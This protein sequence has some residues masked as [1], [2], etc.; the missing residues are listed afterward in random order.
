MA[1]ALNPGVIAPLQPTDQEA[2]NPANN[3]A[4]AMDFDPLSGRTVP[5]QNP[6]IQVIK[7][8]QRPSF[9]HNE[10][11]P[12][13]AAKRPASARP[14]PPPRFPQTYHVTVFRPHGG[15]RVS[16]WPTSELARSLAT[17]SQMSDLQFRKEITLQAQPGPNLIVAGTPDPYLADRLSQVT[18]VT[19]RGTD[20]AV[21][22]YMKPPPGTS[23]G[24]IHGIPENIT[25]EQLLEL[26]AT[27][28]PYLVHARMMGNTRS[29]LLTFNGPRVPY[30]IKFDCELVR[31]RPYRRAVQ[32]CKC[33]GDV[34]HR[35]DVCPQPDQPRCPACGISNPPPDHPCVPRCK[36]CEG[37]HPTAHKDCPKRLLPTPAPR[38]PRSQ[39]NH[40]PLLA[41]CNEDF[42]ALH[43]PPADAGSRSQQNLQTQVSWSAALRNSPAAPNPIPSHPSQ[44]LTP[45]P[46]TYE[47]VLKELKEQQQRF[48]KQ[49]DNL[50]KKIEALVTSP[51]PAPVAPPV[52]TSDQINAAID[53]KL[54]DVLKQLID[55]QGESLAPLC[56]GIQ[57]LTDRQNKLEQAIQGIHDTLASSH[58]TKK[59]KHHPYHD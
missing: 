33:C 11:R 35:H 13:N 39:P 14:I 2:S 53:S 9:T 22:A 30:Y 27:N 29:A 45:V 50:T 32:T 24:V 38:K 12:S 44:P 34:G 7:S 58:P 54:V 49:L 47:S 25:N 55:A 19:L 20:Y 5:P 48:Q 26:T 59:L 41:Y 52:P 17:A 51:L 21:S 15:L 56:S 37:P 10:V 8:R 57:A 40:Q 6:W 16:D 31:C 23:R 36:L 18:T 28:R 3:Q 42:P 43:T 46:P 4:A 1:T